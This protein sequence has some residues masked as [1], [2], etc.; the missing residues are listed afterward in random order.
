MNYASL[1]D[2][3]HSIINKPEFRAAFGLTIR[4]NVRF[5]E[6]SFPG[7]GAKAV[8]HFVIPVGDHRIYH[9]HET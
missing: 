5:K 7:I 8:V 4:F 2:C 1:F 9:P 6:R 3:I